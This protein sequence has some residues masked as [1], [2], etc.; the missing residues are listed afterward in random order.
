MVAHFEAFY[1]GFY[2]MLNNFHMLSCWNCRL[3]KN[4]TFMYY[5]AGSSATLDTKK[6]S[7]V[8]SPTEM[9]SKKKRWVRSRPQAGNNS[10]IHS[11]Y[12]CRMYYTLSNTRKISILS[13]S[14]NLKWIVLCLSGSLNRVIE[15]KC[16]GCQLRYLWKMH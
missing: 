8:V 12:M 9:Q 5:Y 7:A 11:E 6:N 16:S 14:K 1:F 15:G 3:T 13:V 2:W 4:C 10:V